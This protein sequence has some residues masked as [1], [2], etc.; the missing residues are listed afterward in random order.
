MTEARLTNFN[1]NIEQK[2][3]SLFSGNIRPERDDLSR[4]LLLRC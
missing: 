4:F 2:A 3:N 1:Y